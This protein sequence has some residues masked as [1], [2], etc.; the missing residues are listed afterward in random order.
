MIDRNRF[1]AGLF[2]GMNPKSSFLIDDPF[3]ETF[4]DQHR[5]GSLGQSATANS[6]FECIPVLLGY[7]HFFEGVLQSP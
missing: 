3:F 2:C 5:Q 7:D 6:L 4:L 1:T